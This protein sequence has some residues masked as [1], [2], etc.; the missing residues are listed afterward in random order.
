MTDAVTDAMIEAGQ[1]ASLK[2]YAFPLN[3]DHLRE[4][5]LAMEAARQPQL[6]S[7]DGLIKA[8]EEI[9]AKDR[10]GFG[11]A[12]LANVAR[13]ALSRH[14]APLSVAKEADNG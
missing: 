12:A 7:D 5:Y 11:R 1:A 14:K 2:H 10:T 9:V 13:E 6:P 3:N 8:L 4:I